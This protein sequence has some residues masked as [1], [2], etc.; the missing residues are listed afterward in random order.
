[1]KLDKIDEEDS[2]VEAGIISP[3]EAVKSGQ[4]TRHVEKLPDK[5]ESVEP[6]LVPSL[7]KRLLFLPIPV[8]L[9][10]L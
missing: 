7:K 3:T 1:M 9:Q 10:K 5:T 6:M 8:A 4:N 2:Q